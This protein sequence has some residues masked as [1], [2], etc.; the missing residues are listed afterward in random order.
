MHEKQGKEIPEQNNSPQWW[1]HVWLIATPWTVTCQAPLS[2]GFSSQE[3]WNGLPFPSPG[4]FP[5]W[6]IK[7][8][9][10]ALQID[11]L[12][13]EPVEIEVSK[14]INLQLY[15][16]FRVIF[17]TYFL[18]VF[19]TKGLLMSFH[20][21]ANSVTSKHIL[22][23]H[24]TSSFFILLLISFT[25]P[26]NISH[27]LISNI[28][29]Q[30]KTFFCSPGHMNNLGFPRGSGA[31]QETWVQSWVGKI[32]C[33]RAWQPTPASLPG[34]FHG[35]RSLA[36]Y[37]PWGHKESDTTEQLS[38]ARGRHGTCLKT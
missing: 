13:N 25:S 21:E 2:V 22:I 34:Q 33:R 26:T 32:P 29:T 10:P 14:I 16:Y 9:P 27:G 7:P 19:S 8:R 12:T 24:F 4:N 5:D 37:S 23:I 3:Y 6:G 20:V 38:T 17:S 28:A 36:G 18:T 1:S 11:S 35:Q 15:F 30:L 31:M